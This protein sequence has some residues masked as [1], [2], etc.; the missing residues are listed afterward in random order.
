MNVARILAD[1]EGS[2]V[3]LIDGSTTITYDELRDRIGAT[4]AGLA[5]IGVEPGDRVAILAGTEPAFVTAAFAALAAGAVVV[6]LNPDS[7]EPEV[8][9]QLVAVEPTVLLVGEQAVQLARNIAQSVLSIVAFGSPSGTR[10]DGFDEV[11]G[12]A[13]SFDPV[14]VEPGAEAALLFTSGTSG[15]PR[16]VSLS[17]ENM[18]ATQ[19]HL[20]EISP[21]VNSDAVTLGALPLFH[22][23]GLNIVLGSTLAVGGTV[24]L[25]REFHAIDSLE[26]IERN[27]VS[28]V[29]AVPPMWA[30]WASV[31]GASETAFASVN[32]ANSGASALSTATFDAIRDRFGIE[33]HEGYGLTETSGVVSTTTGHAVR[34]GSVGRPLPEVELRLVGDDGVDVPVGDRGEIWVRG[35]NVTGGYWNDLEATGRSI[36]PEG[37]FRTGDIGI[38][39]DDGYLY[40]VDRSKDMI[41]VSGFN[42]FPAEVEEVLLGFH[43][44]VQAVVV[45]EPDDRT[46]ERVVAHVNLTD[47]AA[48]GAMEIMEH[49]RAN[50][51]RYKCPAIVELGEELPVTPT[52]K[53]VRRLLRR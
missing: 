7:P 4:V 5:D 46:G 1:H 33:I 29:A 31:D 12:E 24:V 41:I 18:L 47:G 50:L 44:V 48:A 53:R 30:A 9:R 34:P 15:E 23:Y 26:T 27:G 43:E 40:L 51:A 45:G 3:A 35:P 52:G 20:R 25:E 32:A 42:V 11:F 21:D 39:D 6:P 36:T 16:A 38:T 10:I 22:I 17:H 49:C 19:R 14:S 28:I 13:G 2:S 8:I 37:W